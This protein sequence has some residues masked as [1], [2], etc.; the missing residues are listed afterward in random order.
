[1]KKRPVTFSSSMVAFLISTSFLMHILTWAFSRGRKGTYT[2]TRLLSMRTLCNEMRCC[3]RPG[4]TDLP[5]TFAVV[6]VSRGPLFSAGFSLPYVA[7]LFGIRTLHG[8]EKFASSRSFGV[9]V[10]QLISSLL[11]TSRPKGRSAC[12]LAKYYT[13]KIITSRP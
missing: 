13:V 1:M 12:F 4:S 9:L 10:L 8:L 2:S 3:S 7:S 11:F 5:R 6:K